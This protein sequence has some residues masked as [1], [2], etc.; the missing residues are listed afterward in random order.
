MEEV[1]QREPAQETRV[2]VPGLSERL[3]GIFRPGHFTGVATVVCKLFNMVQPEVA[4][5]GRKD[6]QQL[7]VIRRLVEDLC[8]PVRIEGVDTVREADGLALSSRNGYLSREERSRAPAIYATLR[9]LAEEIRGGAGDYRGLERAGLAR[10]REA[11][12]RPDYLEICRAADLE[13]AK[14]GERRLVILAA[15]WLGRARLID[16]LLLILE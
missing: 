14:A 5:F 11:G 9:H 4:V 15:A 8:L 16:N 6:Y 12:L 2:Q 10:L 1:Y 13:P 3:C 7:L